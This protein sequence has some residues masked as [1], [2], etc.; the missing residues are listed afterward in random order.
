MF[1]KKTN[2]NN[3]QIDQ[4][5]YFIEELYQNYTVLH[6]SYKT[7]YSGDKTIIAFGLVEDI[8]DLS[9]LTAKL[10]SDE[11]IKLFGYFSYEAF[12][13]S[14]TNEDRDFPKLK[15]QHYRNH[16]IINHAS[17]NV[18]FEL[19][20]ESLFNNIL[21]FKRHSHETKSYELRGKLN[22]NMSDNEFMQYVESI[23]RDIASGEYYQLNLTRK[24]FGE[25]KEQADFTSILLG[26]A[27][28]F[29]SPY[30]A[31]IRHDDKYIIS[32]SPERF[33]QIDHGNILSRPIKGTMPKSLG[34]TAKNLYNSAKDRA[35]NLMIIDLMR[36]DLSLSAEFGTVKAGPLFEIDEFANL[37]HMSTNVM[38][39]KKA[40]LTNLD[41][42][43]SA[44]PPASMTGAPKHAVMKK[45][46]ELETLER[47]IYSGAIG[48]FSGSNYCDFNVVIRT[49][50]FDGKKFEYQVGGG[51]TYD[52]DPQL[53]LEETQI[54]AAKI[55]KVL[56]LK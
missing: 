21:A 8:K 34:S 38:A 5:L 40:D 30:S 15:F 29:P 9:G 12:D 7:S 36:N 54:K 41:V 14:N 49:I 37:Y 56:G 18:E 17:S 22:S 35:E 46:T 10:Q 48:Y 51:I 2:K 45:I 1:L 43:K 4:I 55:K 6:S 11:Q 25:F 31:L 53:E 27:L 23:R 26:L 47:G 24:Y 20:S 52:S 44:F 33:I 50:L 3:I 16:I 39:K 19:E 28:E 13:E 42:I 32:S